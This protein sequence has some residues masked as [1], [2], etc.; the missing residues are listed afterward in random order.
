[1]WESCISRVL[2]LYE[3]LARTGRVYLIVYWCSLAGS[4]STILFLERVL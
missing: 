3:H 2:G 4:L 1:M